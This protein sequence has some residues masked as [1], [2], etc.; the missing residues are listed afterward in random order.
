MSKL[1]ETILYVTDICEAYLEIIKSKKFLE[2][3][4]TLGQIMNL[5]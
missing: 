5:K 2:N 1:L 4:L 3:Q